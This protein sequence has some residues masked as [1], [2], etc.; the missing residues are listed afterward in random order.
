MV[1]IA[2][3]FDEKKTMECHTTNDDQEAHMMYTDRNI[4][5][6][7]YLQVRKPKLGKFERTKKLRAC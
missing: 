5:S 6:E 2:D 3:K 7:L 4:S 1:R